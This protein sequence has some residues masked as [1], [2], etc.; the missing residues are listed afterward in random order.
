MQHFTNFYDAYMFLKYNPMVWISNK[1][2]FNYFNECL[3]VE[4]IKND[5]ID[6]NNKN[7][8]HFEMTLSS[9]HWNEEK[10]IAEIIPTLDDPVVGTTYEDAII[11]L[12]N[13]IYDKTKAYN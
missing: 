5:L 12:A 11:R 2:V 10:K 9:I 6:V 1:D 8:Y 7:S 13:N 3:N 4:V